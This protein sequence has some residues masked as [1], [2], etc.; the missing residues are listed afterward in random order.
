MSMMVQFW[1]V[2]IQTE[3]HFLYFYMFAAGIRRGR[4]DKYI[5]NI[6]KLVSDL[7]I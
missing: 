6:F 1:T 7:S 3:F 5:I 4:S 2:E